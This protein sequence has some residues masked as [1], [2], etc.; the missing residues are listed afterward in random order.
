MVISCSI[1]Q[2]EEKY[3]PGLNMVF[4]ESCR[5]LNLIVFTQFFWPNLISRFSELITKLLIATLG[6]CLWLWALVTGDKLP[7][8]QKE[9]N[10]GVLRQCFRPPP[11]LLL[12]LQVCK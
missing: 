4:T 9:Q 8:L 2:K 10:L 6:L 3:A 12:F 1:C 11:S 7:D 5:N